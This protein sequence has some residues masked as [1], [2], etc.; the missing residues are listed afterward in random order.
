MVAIVITIAIIRWLTRTPV[1]SFSGKRTLDLSALNSAIMYKE[2]FMAYLNAALLEP[3]LAIGGMEEVVGQELA[4]N[5]F[6]LASICWWIWVVTDGFDYTDVCQ[7]LMHVLVWI[8]ERRSSKIL[9]NI[10][11]YE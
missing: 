7:C 11:G 8:C 1:Q 10:V 3:V 5:V 2:V 6:T 4:I 9:K